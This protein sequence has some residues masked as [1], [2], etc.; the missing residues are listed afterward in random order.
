MDNEIDNKLK[1]ILY[2]EINT[3]DE[4]IEE[5]YFKHLDHLIDAI[6]KIRFKNIKNNFL[7]IDEM[8]YFLKQGIDFVCTKKDEKYL[9]LITEEII[10]KLNTSINYPISISFNNIH[11]FVLDIYHNVSYTDIF[12]KEIVNEMYS[13]ILNKIYDAYFKITKK[14]IKDE[15]CEK[16]EY[17]KKK[18]KTIITSYKLKKVDELIK[19]R[20]YE[21][22]NLSKKQLKIMIKDKRNNILNM[23]EIVKNK[24]IISEDNFNYFE[25]RFIQGSLNVEEITKLLDCNKKISLKILKKYNEVL[26]DISENIVVD[27]VSK[28]KLLYQRRHKVGFDYNNF[29]IVNNKEYLN[30][31][32]EIIKCLP[33]YLKEKIVSNS[34][35]YEE[36][37]F[38]IP[39]LGLFSE[40]NIDK[41]CQIL[42][43]Y[44]IVK[45][46]ILKQKECLKPF[47]YY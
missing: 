35:V 44:P 22:L 27:K 18:E 13:L 30:Y 2:K 24:I 38:L 41:Y 39:F 37:I 31:V 26:L 16:L 12:P 45:E 40:L 7:S 11:S 42:K 43:N 23:K 29:V 33:E 14:E 32:N 20:E 6:I 46:S 8:D 3:L 28:N 17:T 1:K 5:I 15:L 9:K 4:N 10:N 25:E 21:K 34:K 19:K 36:I 47:L